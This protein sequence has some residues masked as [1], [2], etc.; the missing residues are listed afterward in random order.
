MKIAVTLL[1]SYLYCSRKLFLEKV[2]KLAEPPKDSLLLG[3]IRHALMEQINAM[4]QEIVS[5]ITTPLDR[6]GISKLY[7]RRYLRT[8]K[9][10]VS[11]RAKALK[12]VGAEPVDAFQSAWETAVREADIRAENVA[13]FIEGTGFLGDELWEKLTPKISG[14]VRI[15]SESLGLTGVIDQLRE[16][17]DRVE[18]VELKTGRMPAEGVWPSHKIQLGAY[19]IMLQEGGKTA[20]TG[21]VRYLDAK[22]EK[23]ITVNPFFKKEILILRE[24]VSELLSGAQLPPI[25]VNRNKCQACGLRQQCYDEGLMADKTAALGR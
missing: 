8:V 3:S 14:E 22:A 9:S 16:Y 17:T 20:P 5:S 11:N 4:E 7:K 12:M 19:L 10:L 13:A 18:P 2:L 25:V 6:I 23:D 1:S 21:T 15:E 24:K